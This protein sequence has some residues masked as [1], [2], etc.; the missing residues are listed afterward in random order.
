MLERVQKILAAAGLGSRRKCEELIS[1]GKVKMNGKTIKLGDKADYEK[2]IIEVDGKRIK[3]EE[4]VYYILNKPK[5]YVSTVKEKFGMKTIMDLVKVRERVFPVGRL[6]KDAEGLMLLTN[7]GELANKMMHP[8]YETQKEYFVL[9]DKPFGKEKENML[10]R[11]IV[12]ESRKV[13]PH[14]IA[15]QNKKVVL[16]IHEGRKHIVKRL[17]EK[18]G[19]KVKR[20]VR[21]RIATLKLGSL[22]PGKYRK[23]TQ[24]ELSTLRGALGIR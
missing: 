7:D 3:P 17:F 15:I 16:T 1:Q 8:R 18:I 19:F 11:G 12:I 5:G 2:D 21:T 20:L 6:D 4:K 13:T 22:Q 9:L 24:G 10:K 23:L 14:K